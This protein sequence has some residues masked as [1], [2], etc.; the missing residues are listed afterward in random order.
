VRRHPIPEAS[1]SFVT[2]LPS[3]MNLN[4]LAAAIPPGKSPADGYGVYS[5]KYFG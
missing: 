3:D 1:M 2:Q 5:S 4:A